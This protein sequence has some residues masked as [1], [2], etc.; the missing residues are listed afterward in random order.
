MKLLT[1]D[2]GFDYFEQL[3][4]YVPEIICLAPD[5]CMVTDEEDVIENKFIRSFTL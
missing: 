5:S 3:N 1:V 2:Q 4:S